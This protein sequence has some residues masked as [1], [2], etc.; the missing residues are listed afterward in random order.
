[1]LPGVFDHNVAAD[2]QSAGDF[3]ACD[4]MGVECS[5]IFLHGH[6]YRH[7]LPGSFRRDR[8]AVAAPL[9]TYLGVAGPCPHRFGEGRGHRVITVS[10]QSL[11]PAFWKGFA[12]L[13]LSAL[14]AGNQPLTRQDSSAETAYKELITHTHSV[15][16]RATRFSRGLSPRIRRVIGALWRGVTVPTEIGRCG[17][18]RKRQ[19]DRPWQ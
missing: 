15:Q 19:D 12:G 18:A 2:A 11:I 13:I 1:V 6:G 16:T 5:D 8:L 10:A 4:S 14:L 3:T 17:P 9:G 7:L